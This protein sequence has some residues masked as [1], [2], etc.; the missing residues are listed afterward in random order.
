MKTTLEQ[1]LSARDARAALQRCLLSDYPEQ[2]LL[3]ATVVMPGEDKSN[4]QSKVIAKAMQQ[5]LAETF[6]ETA[7]FAICKDL[8]TGYEHY[9]LLDMPAADAKRLA[10]SL[11][12]KRPLGRLF[13]IDVIGADGVPLQRT[14]YGFSPRTCLLCSNAAGVCMRQRSHSSDEVTAKIQSLIDDYLL[15]IR[16]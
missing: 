13:D 8:P 9:M 6:R 4:P 15:R 5:A 14:D 10:C 2:T 3:C 1:V 7:R 16:N 12:D 11:E